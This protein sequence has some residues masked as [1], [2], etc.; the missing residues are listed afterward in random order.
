MLEVNSLKVKYGRA[1]A[2]KGVS[3]T[4]GQGKVVA[5][6]GSN[7]AG[8]STLLKAISGLV[9][10]S[11]E[12]SIRLNGEEISGLPPDKIVA[13]GISYVP[14]GRKIFPGLTVRE[15]LRIG[16]YLRQDKKGI[17]EDM[18]RCYELFPRLKER[19]NQRA[20]TLSG[21]EQQMLAISRALM[22]KPKLLLLD[23]PSM[24]LA[25]VLVE[26]IY[27]KI[28][29]IRE[30]GVTMLLVEQNANL[31]LTISDYVYVIANG[32]IKLQGAAKDFLRERDL[33]K[34][35]LGS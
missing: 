14:E 1:E 22:S 4:V 12:S 2:L 30:Q 33:V 5:V 11:K 27:E 19:S 7:G 13:K 10:V 29:Q 18:E 3:L 32:E 17:E 35:Y 20:G 28:A 16:A 25:P 9:P 21:G 8:K 31:A 23:E 15:N 24:G 34:A 6:L 26:R